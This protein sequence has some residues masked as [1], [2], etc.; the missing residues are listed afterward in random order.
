MEKLFAKDVGSNEFRKNSC[1]YQ[2]QRFRLHDGSKALE[3]RD[4]A[5]QLH[6]PFVSLP[7][8]HIDSSFL[9]GLG[10]ATFGPAS[11]ALLKVA[12]SELNVG[13]ILGAL[14]ALSAVAGEHEVAQ[15]LD[16]LFQVTIVK[17]QLRGLSL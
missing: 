11:Q 17:G 16:L 2:V 1:Q 13:V 6:Q 5:N 8:K 12:D 7:A 4:W 14:S 3:I 10:A 15:V 9:K